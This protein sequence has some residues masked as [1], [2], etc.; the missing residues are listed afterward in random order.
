M[1]RDATITQSEVNAVAERLNAAGAKPTARAIR[2]ALGSGSLA[3]VL[4]FLQVWRAGQSR[5]AESPLALPPALQ[6]SLLEFIAQEVAT[7]RLALETELAIAEQ[8]SSDLV[9]ESE[10]QT[11]TLDSQ[12]REIEGLR[13]ECAELRGRL[14]QLTSDLE[15]GRAALDEQRLA[16]QIA[17]TELARQELRLEALPRLEAELVR[18]QA[19]REEERAARVAAEQAAAVSA[20]RL[21]KTEA[22]VADLKERLV[23]AEADEHKLPRERSRIAK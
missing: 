15:A 7:A 16:A 13:A 20:A 17:R 18:L 21:E 3:T 19:A 9:A 23:R 6:R 4:K 5:Q 10:R 8:T 11:A 1:G 12:E 2:E 14:A 22:Q